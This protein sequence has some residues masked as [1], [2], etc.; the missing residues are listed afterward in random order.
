MTNRIF[1]NNKFLSRDG[2]FVGKATGGERHCNMESCRG[3]RLAI[4]WNDGKLT[5]PCT[6]GMEYNTKK[7]AWQLS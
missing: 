5:Y 3:V 7:K 4:R 6:A 2:K 1:P